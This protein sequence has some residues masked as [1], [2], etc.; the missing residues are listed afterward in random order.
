MRLRDLA[1]LLEQYETEYEAL[2]QVKAGW[3]YWL[4]Q[5]LVDE[6]ML[7]EGLIEP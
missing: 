5:R 4:A 7:A 1:V 2:P 3:F 6:G